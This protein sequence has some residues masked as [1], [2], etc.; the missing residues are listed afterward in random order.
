MI[1]FFQKITALLLLVPDVQELKFE[2][3]CFAVNFFYGKGRKLRFFKT[4][5]LLPFH[6]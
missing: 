3:K 1:F 5:S 6:M 4:K 2:E